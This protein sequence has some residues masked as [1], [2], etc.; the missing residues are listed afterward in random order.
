MVD[1]DREVVVFFL[2]RDLVDVD[3]GDVFEG[4]VGF[5]Y[6]CRDVLEDCVYS[7]LCDF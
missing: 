4:V 2:V 5:L 7:V 3:V 1:D 6:A